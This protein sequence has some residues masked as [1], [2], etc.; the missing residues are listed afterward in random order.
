MTIREQ[1]IAAAMTAIGDALAASGLSA[2]LYRSRSEAFRPGQL[3]A[4]VVRPES[5]TPGDRDGTLCWCPWTMVMA[6]DVV[7]NEAPPCQAADPFADLIH[8]ALLADGEDL[9][10]PAYSVDIA[11]GPTEW[12]DENNG[13]VIGLT[14]QRF[15]VRYRT[16]WPDLALSL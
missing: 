1:I 16:S 9:G 15:V 11:P 2:G 14:T 10:L 8:R 5:D 13:E 6:V 7:V 4:I 12:T 3:P